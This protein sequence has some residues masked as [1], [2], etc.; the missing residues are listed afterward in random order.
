MSS[1]GIVFIDEKAVAPL[2]Y[3]FENRE[4]KSLANKPIRRKSWKRRL[5]FAIF[6]L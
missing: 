1:A 4:K 6:V 3:V 2:V 5:R